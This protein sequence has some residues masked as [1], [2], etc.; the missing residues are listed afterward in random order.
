M[1][2]TEFTGTQDR[3]LANILCDMVDCH[4]ALKKVIEAR[5]ENEDFSPDDFK[6]LPRHPAYFGMYH[7][8]DGYMNT[9]NN[10]PSH[11]DP[12]NQIYQLCS[13]TLYSLQKY[14]DDLLNE[15][16]AIEAL[17]E[18]LPLDDD[19]RA[20]TNRILQTYPG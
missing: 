17:R 7:G 13:K 12:A 3:A 16:R 4:K 14:C 1:E 10:D 2:K 18:S 6:N 8:R 15:I 20:S 9:D 5:S 19:Y 11:R